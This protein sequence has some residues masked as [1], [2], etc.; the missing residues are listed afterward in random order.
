[1]TAASRG[2]GAK[3]VRL[4]R[5]E[6]HE[7]IIDAGLRV[8]GDRGFRGASMT[9]VA[10]EC[11]VAKGLLYEHYPSKEE[12]YDACVERQRVALFERLT[13]AVNEAETDPLREFVREFFNYIEENRDRS[14]ILYGEASA[15]A[16][17]EMRARN[18]EEVAGLL[19]TT[20]G[21]AASSLSPDQVNMLA[22]GLVG[23]GEHLAR[24][25]LASEVPKRVA[26]DFHYAMA[27]GAIVFAIET[28]AE[29]APSP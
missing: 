17:N 29:N 12:L 22:N 19:A 4:T 23:Q 27:A 24:W 8:F 16:A 11:G 28:T 13:Q 7:L 14:W 2:S 10:V 26:V 9:D 18:G 25:W 3:R 15:A 20:P 6:R 21:S 1:M 5:P